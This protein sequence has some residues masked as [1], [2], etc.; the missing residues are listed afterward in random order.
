[1]LPI[2]LNTEDKKQILLNADDNTLSE[3]SR[4]NEINA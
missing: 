1:M 4:E 2:I 3:I